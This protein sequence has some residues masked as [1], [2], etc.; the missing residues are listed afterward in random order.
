M[1]IAAS[2]AFSVSRSEVEAMNHVVGHEL[3][4]GAHHRSTLSERRAQGSS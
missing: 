3:I 2:L 4:C 1:M